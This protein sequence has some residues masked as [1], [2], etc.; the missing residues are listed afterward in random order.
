[1][2][3]IFLIILTISMLGLVSCGDDWLDREPTYSVLTDSDLTLRE[4]EALATDFYDQLRDSYYYGG[5]FLYYGDVRGDDMQ[6]NGATKRVANAYGYGF[7]AEN[8]PSATWRYPYRLIRTANK[9]ILDVDKLSIVEG[10]NDA[11][12]RD[13]VKGQA[14][15]MR[16]FAYFDLTRLFCNP[17]LKDGGASMG[18]CLLDPTITLPEYESPG[19]STVKEAYDEVIIPDLIEAIPL[20]H[21][22]KKDT[23]GQVSQLFAKQLLARAYLYMGEW[24]KAYDYAEEVI[25]EHEDNGFT[26]WT[27][28]EISGT[29]IWNSHGRSEALLEL[30]FSD[31]DRQSNDGISYLSWENGYDDV[32]LTESFHE[33]WDKDDLRYGSVVKGTKSRNKPS[34]N[35]FGLQRYFCGK[36]GAEYSNPRTG[37]LVIMRV[38]EAYLIA[39]EASCELGGAEAAKGLEYFNVIRERAGL[40]KKDAITLDDVLEERRFEFYGE[41]HR[42]FDLLRRGET[43]YRTGSGHYSQLVQESMG[44]T[45]IDWDHQLSIFGIPQSELRANETLRSQQNPGW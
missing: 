42:S 43:I 27:K 6:T 21:K 32:I 38:S 20:L 45:V 5:R 24:K 2:R 33:A 40:A 16:A 34:K 19:R 3:K 12:L 30:V 39:A 22:K 36:F 7:N 29:D 18:P 23:D 14:L 44:N 10:S 41:G 15:A 35:E 13:H 31:T 4:A 37:S 11:N 1:M 26:L 25:E 8:I 9:I 28:D 17:Y